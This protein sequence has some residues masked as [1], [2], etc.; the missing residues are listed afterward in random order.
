M[1]KGIDDLSGSRGNGKSC[2]GRIWPDL[3][4]EARNLSGFGDVRNRSKG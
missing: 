4:D 3:D 2:L 1:N